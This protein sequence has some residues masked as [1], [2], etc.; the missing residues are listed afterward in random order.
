LGQLAEAQALHA[1]GQSDESNQALERAQT[2]AQAMASGILRFQVL[3]CQALFALDAGDEDRCAAA[4]GEAF[5]LGDARG[6]VSFNYFR[7]DVMARLC[8]LALGRA[9]EPGYARRLVRG[10]GLRPPSPDVEY[11]PWPVRIYTLGRFSLVVDGQPV[12][13]A[14]RGQHKPIELLQALI[15][16]G[17][18]QV[19]GALLVEQ[20]WPDAH[21]KGGRGALES[22][23]LRLRRLL[24]RED[25]ILLDG[26]RLTLNPVLCWVDVWGL[27]RALGRVH[28]A[29]LDQPRPDLD[30]LTRQFR[31]A[32]RLWQGEFLQRE[33]PQTWLL[34]VRKRLVD[35]VE[36]LVVSLGTRLEAESLWEAAAHLYRRAIEI[37]PLAE[38]AY[39]RLMGCLRESG[40][41]TEALRVYAT[42]R[43]AL[44]QGLRVTPSAETEAVRR[45]IMAAIDAGEPRAIG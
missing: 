19:S 6:Y 28:A 38:T 18:R 45:S 26:G 36:Q 37:A 20:L 4:L 21:S 11:W 44:A 8:A 33:T 16:L 27:E 30:G 1:A 25:A 5:A 35:Q 2:I 7:P 13:E 42:C 41:P 17:G 39:R 43:A 40:A 14:G 23:L 3:L 22:S 10:N 12:A 34:P 31:K 15:A 24:G 32:L 9:I 29:L